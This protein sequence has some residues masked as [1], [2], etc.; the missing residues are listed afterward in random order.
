MIRICFKMVDFPDSPAPKRR[1]LTC[2]A[3]TFLSLRINFSI[4]MFLLRSSLVVRV[5]ALP[6]DLGKHMLNTMEPIS[7]TRWMTLCTWWTS[8]LQGSQ[9][10]SMLTNRDRFQLQQRWDWIRESVMARHAKEYIPSLCSKITCDNQ[11]MPILYDEA[12]LLMSRSK[13]HRRS[14]WRQRM[15]LARANAVPGSRREQ[16]CINAQC[17]MR[18]VWSRDNKWRNEVLGWEEVVVWPP[19]DL[20]SGRSPLRW[21]EMVLYVRGPVA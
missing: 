21:I 18:C 14:L 19:Q 15:V 20:S 12:L 11:M 2:L 17:D 8:N 16:R 4:S 5:R 6:P 10:I 9:L 3:C 1:I 7:F 13:A